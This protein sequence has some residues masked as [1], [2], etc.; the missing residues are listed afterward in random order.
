MD[1]T[2]FPSDDRE[3]LSDEVKI[4]MSML[5][6]GTTVVTI[7]DNTYPNCCQPHA[8][9][10]FM[11][12]LSSLA[13]TVADICVDFYPELKVMRSEDRMKAEIVRHYIQHLEDYFGPMLESSLVAASNEASARTN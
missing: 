9:G 10:K 8:K 11:G 6:V 3:D 12:L 1:E 13:H 7:L 2:E 5:A 4:Q